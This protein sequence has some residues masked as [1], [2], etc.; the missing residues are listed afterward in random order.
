M[1][2]VIETTDTGWQEK[3]TI[4]RTSYGIQFRVQENGSVRSDEGITFCGMLKK[5]G[6]DPAIADRVLTAIDLPVGID[7]GFAMYSAEMEVL[8]E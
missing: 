2:L 5:R 6:V 3:L 4:G 8:R 7:V 1:K